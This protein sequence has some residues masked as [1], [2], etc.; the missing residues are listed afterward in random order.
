MNVYDFDG[1]IYQ[2]DS[3]VDFYVYC[4]KRRP[5]LF[6]ELPRFFRYCVLY[7]LGKV[8]K[9]EL[10]EVYFHFLT[11]LDDAE[12]FVR[13]FWN[14]HECRIKS[15]YL[16]QKSEE[17]VVITASPEFLILEICKRL[18]IRRL[19]ATKVDIH[20]GNFLS[21]NCYGN[22]KVKR[23]RQ[24]FSEKKIGE[25]YSDSESDLPMARIAEHAYL[26]VNNRLI[27]WNVK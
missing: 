12:D 19:I 10:K 8:S 4:L 26:V 11:K 15:W 21:E 5:R 13:Q 9:R 18:G 1:T 24:V 25:F 7:K 2:G 17:D 22:E 6:L 14:R 16:Q 27:E 3:S 20:S 23:F